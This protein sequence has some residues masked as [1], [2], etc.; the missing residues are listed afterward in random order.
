MKI[1]KSKYARKLKLIIRKDRGMYE[2]EEIKN[3]IKGLE[4]LA[5]Y[6]LG[7]E[8]IEYKY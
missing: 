7:S 3:T 8:T 4:T 6:R 5:R 2:R 1:E